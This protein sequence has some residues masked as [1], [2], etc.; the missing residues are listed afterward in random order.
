MRPKFKIIL[1]RHE[2]G[3]LIFP[4]ALSTCNTTTNRM[5]A[6]VAKNKKSPWPLTTGF[7]IMFLSL[8]VSFLKE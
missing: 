8:S 7:K 2:K 3:R 1:S 6:P 5:A 4:Y